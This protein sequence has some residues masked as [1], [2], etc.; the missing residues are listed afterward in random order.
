MYELQA[1]SQK[2][3]LTGE[4]ACFPLRK[5]FYLLLSVAT[6]LM[7]PLADLRCLYLARSNI[8][9]PQGLVVFTI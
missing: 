8:C 1:V 6:S 9:L 5:G 2:L 7:E 3:E 4:A